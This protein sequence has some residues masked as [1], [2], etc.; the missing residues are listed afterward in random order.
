MINEC[1]QC[2][3]SIRFSPEQLKKIKKAMSSLDEGKLLT[4]KCPHCHLPIKLDQNGDCE[5]SNVAPP[6]PPD[7]DWLA[8]GNFQGEEKVEDIPMAMFLLEP[9]KERDVISEAIKTV[10]YHIIHAEDSGDA[11]ER[12]RFVNFDC[13]IYKVDSLEALDESSFHQHMCA[14]SMERRRYMFYILV[15]PCFNTLYN[16]EALACSANLVVNSKDAPHFEV[17]LRKSIPDYE[18]MFGPY[19]EEIS[20]SGVR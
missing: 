11:I 12:M 2:Q 7:L 5:T 6:S 17:L 14:M 10:G 9:S 3:K 13:V 16:L 15:G 8:S 19:I 1:P 4:L 18:E 20:A